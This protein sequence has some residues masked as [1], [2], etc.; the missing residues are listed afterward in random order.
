MTL[1]KILIGLVI[2]TALIA[3][4]LADTYPS[5]LVRVIVPFPAG[6]TADVVARTATQKLSDLWA[7]PV[8]V[9]NRPGAGGTIGVASVAKSAPDGYVLLAHSSS[10]AVSPAVYASLPYDP[11]KDLVEVAPVGTQPYVLVVGPSS[12]PTSIAQLIAAAKAR[13]GALSFG[14]AGVGSSTHLVAEKFKSAAG[15]DIVHVPYKAL[16]DAN[17]DVMTGRVAFWFPPLGL[18]LPLIH[19]H[20]LLALG[21]T[22]AR[23]T[24][25]L[26]DVPTMTEAGFQA[27]DDTNWFGVWAPGHTS[28]EIVDK[29]S[30]D[31]GRALQ[32]ADV[33]DRLTATGTTPMSMTRNEF[34]RFVRSEMNAAARV[35]KAAGIKP[36]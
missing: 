19:D 23:R 35:V 31:V 7:Q 13:P 14:S 5:K 8:V 18:V 22:G 21:V 10:Y 1:R 28:P 3:D 16:S 12:A 2:G 30:K 26:A 17:A 29:I 33:R 32:A 36:E 20:K 11:A 24:S 27:L 25:F 6:S 9:E 15:M 4:A 34:A